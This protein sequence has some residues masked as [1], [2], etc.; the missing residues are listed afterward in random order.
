MTCSFDIFYFFL[1]FYSKIA[2]Y[3]LCQTSR[4]GFQVGEYYILQTCSIFHKAR[5]RECSQPVFSQTPVS[6]FFI[7]LWHCAC[8]FFFFFHSQIKTGVLGHFIPRWRL[9]WMAMLN[10]QRILHPLAHL[11]HQ[12]PS[13]GTWSPFPSFV[14][15]TGAQALI[16]CFAW[17]RDDCC[18]PGRKGEHRA[19]LLVRSSE[20]TK[21]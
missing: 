16:W 9:R 15:L 18:S 10:I 11:E 6:S 19:I 20:K 13:F 1:L 17:G 3:S 7:F 5:V 21:A 8:F 14:G 12:T 2:N 4:K